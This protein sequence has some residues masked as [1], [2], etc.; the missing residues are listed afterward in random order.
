MKREHETAARYLHDGV[1]V[2]P[3]D[4]AAWL[5]TRTDF[6]RG[7]QGTRGAD[8]RRDAV[9]MALTLGGHQHLA[10]ASGSRAAAEPEVD[11]SLEWLSTGRASDL[12]GMS[13]RAVRAACA[14]G[15]LAAQRVAGRYRISRAALDQYCMDRST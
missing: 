10:S 6:N 4:V 11:P 5:V 7:R 1:V 12:L 8:P 15:R 13:D 9:L 3:M 14:A 2:V